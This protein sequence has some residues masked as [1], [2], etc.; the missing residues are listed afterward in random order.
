MTRTPEISWQ[1]DEVGSRALQMLL[2]LN[3]L[4]EDPAQTAIDDLR[5]KLLYELKEHA[6]LLNYDLSHNLAH[7]HVK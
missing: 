6:F 1:L 2:L 4:S 3:N 7:V 5:Q